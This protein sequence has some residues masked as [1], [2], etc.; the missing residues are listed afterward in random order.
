MHDPASSSQPRSIELKDYRPPDYRVGTVNLQF[1]LNASKTTVTSLLTVVCNHE[2]CEGIHPL[3]LH[4]RYLTLRSLKLDGQ[5]L[6][7][8]DYRIDAETLTVLPVPDRFVLEIMTEIDPAAN[9]ELSGL[10]HAS[11]MFCTQCE[12]EG[13]RKITY[14]PDRPD[15]LAR[16]FTTIVADKRNYPVLLSNGNLIGKATCRT[17]GTSPSGTIL[18]E[19]RVPLRARRRG[20]VARRGPVHD[21]VR[22]GGDPPDLRAAP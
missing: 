20:P 3:V 9:T 15:V 11:G 22:E 5:T 16:F 17:A 13:F 7:E 8:R 18:P 21:D 1:D 2:R 12:A 10:Y 14:Y 6:T 19:A 4:G